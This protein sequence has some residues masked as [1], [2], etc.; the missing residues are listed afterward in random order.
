MQTTESSS[1]TS[2]GAI[3]WHPAEIFGKSITLRSALD[4]L[5]KPLRKDT[6]LQEMDRDLVAES[7]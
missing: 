5:T 4:L 2:G 1:D 7:T 3:R 6:V